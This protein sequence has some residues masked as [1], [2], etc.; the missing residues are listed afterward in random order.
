M[1]ASLVLR[2]SFGVSKLKKTKTVSFGLPAFKSLDGFKVCPGSG[3]CAEPC[4]AQQARYTL[5]DA[6]RTRETNLAIVRASL[7]LFERLATHDLERIKVRSIRLH[8][9]GDFYSQEYLDSWFSIM[10]QFPA[11]SFYCYTKSLQLDW[12]A[13]PINFTRV[14]SFG[15]RFDHLID[16]SK[17]H[18]RI[19]ATHADRRRAGYVDGNRDDGP[20]QRGVIRI[21]LV[22]HGTRA[23]TPK[24][25]QIMRRPA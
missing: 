20:A 14:Q 8:D 3:F 2:W 11:K 7:P 13:T 4:Y 6:I 18:A 10:R 1:S 15:G 22:Y 16:T 25:I 21:G 19:F 24:L 9:S 12:T 23:L 5:P 17:P